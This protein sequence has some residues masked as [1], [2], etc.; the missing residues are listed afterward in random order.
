MEIKTTIY[1][2]FGYLMVGVVAGIA[3]L[4]GYCH[5]SG[6]D[7]IPLLSG[8]LEFA[9]TS[10]FILLLVVAYILGH[11]MST[12]SYLLIDRPVHNWA[13]FTRYRAIEEIVSPEAH[14]LYVEKFTARFGFRPSD[15]DFPLSGCYVQSEASSAYQTAFV[16]LAFYGMAR[17]ITCVFLPYG[18]WEIIN[19]VVTRSLP[20]LVSAVT[21]LALAC[22][23]FYHYLRFLKYY[24]QQIISAFLV[25]SGPPDIPKQQDAK[26]DCGA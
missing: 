17:N 4:I 18:L 15:G 19:S 6:H 22:V 23:F 8:F 26:N 20:F 25:A 11:A 12:M 24:K 14:A 13:L 10:G 9:G 7:W 16:F 3:S 2:I 1:D 21:A 5:S